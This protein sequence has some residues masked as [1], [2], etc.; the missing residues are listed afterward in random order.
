MT[1]MKCENSYDDVI[2]KAQV[3]NKDY[4]LSRGLKKWNGLRKMLG[5]MYILS[6]KGYGNRRE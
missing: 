1:V 4:Y 5:V 3:V 6:L 2:N